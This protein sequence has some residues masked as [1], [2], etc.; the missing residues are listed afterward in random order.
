MDGFAVS[1]TVTQQKPTN[2]LMRRLPVMPREAS[3][4]DAAAPSFCFTPV[5]APQ[6]WPL[7]TTVHDSL[8]PVSFSLVLPPLHFSFY[9]ASDT[10]HLV[11]LLVDKIQCLIPPPWL[12]PPLL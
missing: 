9:H 5:P 11:A 7:P 3:S 2:K 8:A 6:T 4:V 12:S 10:T 1:A